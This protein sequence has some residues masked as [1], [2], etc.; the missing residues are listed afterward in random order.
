VWSAYLLAEDDDGLWLHTPAGSLYRGEDG[1]IVGFC[2]S[3]MDADGAGRSM[4]QL[5]P[6]SGWWIAT[7]VGSNAELAIAV[8][9]CRPPTLCGSEWTYIDLELDPYLTRD[10]LVGTDDWDEFLDACASGL[11][12][13]DEEE[14]A[15]SATA[16]IEQ[17]LTERVEP[18]GVTGFHWLDA[19]QCMA[20]PP[21][22]D[23]TDVPTFPTAE[24]AEQRTDGAN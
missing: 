22:V 12:S 19:A 4:V 18:F 16:Q 5:I 2:E 7:W 8:D 15:R 23:L 9:I 10:G 3:A 13:R 17:W 1:Q 20:L 14:A 21:L 11:I 24:L 6:R